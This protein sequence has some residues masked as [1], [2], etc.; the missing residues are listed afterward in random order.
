M[1][2]PLLLVGAPYLVGPVDEHEE[3]HLAFDQVSGRNLAERTLCR[4]AP[5]ERLRV[6]LLPIDPGCDVTVALPV[7]R[8][9][10]GD[11]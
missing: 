10:G 7:R 9:A 8:Q 11:M 3:R 2:D 4:T 1:R 5:D 6:D